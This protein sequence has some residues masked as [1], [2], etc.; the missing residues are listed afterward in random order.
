[1]ADPTTA[2]MSFQAGEAQV[3]RD[4][5]PRDATT[6]KDLGYKVQWADGNMYVLCPD[7][8]PGTGSPF[9]DPKVREAVE[10]AIDKEE[11]VDSFG[12]GFW[13]AQYEA[14]PTSRPAAYVPGLAERKYDPDK[15]KQLLADA[16]YPDGFDTTIYAQVSDDR[17][18]LT[19][20]QSYLADVGINAKIDVAEPA[21][22]ME[23]GAKGWVNG[24]RYYYPGVDM[25]FR[26]AFNAFYS[27][28]AGAHFMAMDKPVNMTDAI[29]EANETVDSAKVKELMQY[30]TKQL[31]DNA[32]VI[33]LWTNSII[34]AM[35]DTVHDC[36]IATIDIH[37]WHAAPIWLS[38]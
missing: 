31:Y 3:I 35:D 12:Y 2:V 37:R 24:L 19:A 15:A 27:A 21:K 9:I 38:K 28:D 7:S 10:Y 33:P 29:R 17:E 34:C 8:K 36:D 25:D 6:L 11:M 13:E 4:L 14:A 30:A 1:M 18:V 22:F 16:G 20:I 26:S 23:Q 5:K 32:L